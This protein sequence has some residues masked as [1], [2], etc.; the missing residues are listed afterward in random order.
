[1]QQFMAVY[2]LF[3]ASICSRSWTIYIHIILGLVHKKRLGT[4]QKSLA[5]IGVKI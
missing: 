4:A 3:L 2:H 1:M 5:Y